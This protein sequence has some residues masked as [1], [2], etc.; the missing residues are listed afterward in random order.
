MIRTAYQNIDALIYLG[1]NN[2]LAIL[3][4]MAVQFAVTVS[5][6]PFTTAPERF[7]AT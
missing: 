3:S 1:E 4:I 7:W 5:N 2:T 6:C